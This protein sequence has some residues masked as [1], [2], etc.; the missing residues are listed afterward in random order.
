MG[1]VVRLLLDMRWRKT[2]PPSTMYQP[3]AIEWGKRLF[4]SWTVE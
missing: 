2:Q 3:Y 1:A 4:R